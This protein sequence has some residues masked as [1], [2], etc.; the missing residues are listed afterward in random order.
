MRSELQSIIND[1]REKRDR[2]DAQG[3]QDNESDKDN[4]KDITHTIFGLFKH[5]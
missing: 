4:M 1:S 2:D 3:R 5:G